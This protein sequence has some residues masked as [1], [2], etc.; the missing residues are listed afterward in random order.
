MA[1]HA[2]AVN[3]CKDL[4][5]RAVLE[6]TINV[7]GPN[8][9]VPEIELTQAREDIGSSGEAISAREVPVPEVEADKGGDEGHF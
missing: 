9:D 7:R 6:E 5:L 8:V 3:E 2:V 1:W 4:Q